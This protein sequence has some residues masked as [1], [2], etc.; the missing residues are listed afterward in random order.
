[1]KEDV[2]K[3]TA[4]H[5]ASQNC[6]DK[7]LK[8]LL[9]AFEGEEYKKTLIEYAMKKNKCKLT[10]LHYSGKHG[11][12]KNAKLL[13]NIFEEKEKLLEYVFIQSPHKNEGTVLHFASEG[14]HVKTVTALLN[15]FGPE[16]K[17]ILIQFLMTTN[18][19]GE[20]ALMRACEK[21]G[22]TGER[23][24]KL[25]LNA[26]KEK[27]QLLIEYLMITDKEDKGTA[28][29]CASYYKGNI[30][31]FLLNEFGRVAKE[32]LIEQFLMKED[33]FGQTVF[34]VW[35]KSI[36]TVLVDASHEI[37]EKVTNLLLNVFGEEAPIKLLEY[38]K[39]TLPNLT[40]KSRGQQ[41]KIV[42]LLSEKI[43]I[44]E[45]DR[46]LSDLQQVQQ[47]FKN[48][49]IIHDTDKT[50]SSILLSNACCLHGKQ[51]ILSFLITGY[52][53]EIHVI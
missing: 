43:H 37:Y 2:K 45:N 15:V 32:K 14:G 48:Y 12:E 10:A 4:L 1:M 16:D 33:K 52:N 39:E 51:T 28:L 34:H 50:L 24:V 6:S 25:L 27:E 40:V 5:Y 41:E 13:L 3:N 36:N 44:K 11:Y 18:T 49:M 8:L 17:E 29:H 9:H 20:T 23:I 47:M 42:E 30:V 35:K 53:H 19:T 31:E 21:E 7:K 38:V 26:F 46:I 22:E